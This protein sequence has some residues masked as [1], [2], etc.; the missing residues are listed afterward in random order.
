MIGYCQSALNNLPE[1]E[2]AFQ[3]YIR[4]VPNNPNPYDSYAELLL[5]MGKY[6][7]S[8]AQYK[9]AL[10]KDPQFVTS[11]AGIGNNFV[12][13]GDF[14]Q[15]RKYYQEY[16]D[17]SVSVNGKLDALFLKAVTYVHEGNKEQA[18]ATFDQYRALAEKEN[19]PTNSINSYAFQG[20]TA[21]ES[22]DAESG[23]KYFDK[24]TDL[25]SKSEL[26]QTTK[27]NLITNSMLWRFYSLTANN[28]LDKAQAEYEKC[29]E[30]IE[31]RK[32]P[33]EVMF[34]N[35]LL[36][37]L[38]IK[39]GEYDNAIKYFSQADNQDPWNW[40][41]TAVA[42]EKK[43]DTQNSEKILDRITKYNVNSLNLAFVRNHAK[44]DLK[45]IM[46]ESSAASAK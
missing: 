41:F 44:E 13:K 14:E 4:L 25:I 18:V 26:P 2:K 5:K 6:D 8:I 45:S 21:T 42:Y 23:M 22:G 16:S 24:A 37:L 28:D 33:N 20:F 29:K 19:L 9:R 11:L 36:G 32:N 10:E 35:S 34:L 7:E 38:E 30:R 39:K 31:S 15:A 1:A 27:E 12:F 40:Y 46:S 17:K 43:G 3:S